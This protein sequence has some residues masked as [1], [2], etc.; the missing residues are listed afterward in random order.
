MAKYLL[1]EASFIHGFYY[2]QGT[3]VYLDDE[4]RPAM[5]WIP[6]DDAAKKAVD[7]ENK[8]RA[9][10]GLK[11]ED[12]PTVD[13]LIGRLRLAGYTVTTPDEEGEMRVKV[14]EERE[15]EGGALVLDDTGQ[16]VTKKLK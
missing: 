2:P 1:S 6:M 13:D 12:I 5:V 4:V 9:Q 8:V 11:F 10:K 7:I 3:T 15:Q 14:A 16:T